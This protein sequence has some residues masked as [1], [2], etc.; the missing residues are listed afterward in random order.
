MTKLPEGDSVDF[1][2]KFSSRNQKPGKKKIIL[3]I[4]VKGTGCINIILTANICIPDIDVSCDAIDFESLYLG[5]S[6]KI[7]FRIQNITPILAN[8]SV[9][10][11][12]SG[13]DVGKFIF[14]P[15]EGVLRSGKKQIISVEF[16]PSEAKKHTLESTIKIEQNAKSKVLVL[17]S[18]FVEF[19]LR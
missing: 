14:Q 8:W 16:I 6:K 10:N 18:S 9:K 15:S 17:R 1:V 11:E 7:F 4:L 12:N 5:C 3:P 13:R 2:V 19:T